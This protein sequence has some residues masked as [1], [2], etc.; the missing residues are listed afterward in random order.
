MSKKLSKVVSA[1]SKSDF[2]CQNLLS[3][4]EIETCTFTD[5]DIKKLIETNCFP[6]ET[7]FHPFDQNLRSDMISKKW[8]CFPVTPF[9][10]GFTYPFPEIVNEFFQRTG[11]SYIQAMPMLWRVLFMVNH[12]KKLYVLDF[13]I[14]ELASIYDIKSHGSSR[15]LLKVKP[16][17]EHLILKTTQN[18]DL[19]KKQF[20][21]V[22]RSSIEGGS[23]LPYRWHTGRRI[24]YLVM[25]FSFVFFL[26]DNL[27]SIFLRSH[28]VFRVG[29]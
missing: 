2:Y 15:Y 4:P 10:M 29:T 1:V 25:Y 23:E 14:E 16:G 11:L 28:Q 17:H 19:W 8:V 21:F 5:L 20:F 27:F 12:L 3:R 18:Y 22:E 24:L 26:Q 6:N 13:D 9:K 7:V